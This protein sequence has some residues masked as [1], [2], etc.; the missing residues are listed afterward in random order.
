MTGSGSAPGPLVH[1][2]FEQTARRLPDKLALIV[3]GQ[4]L[5]YD[6]LAQRVGAA[7]AALARAGVLPGERVLVFLDSGIEFAVAMLAVWQRG[8]VLVPVSALTKSDK[9]AFVLAD[10]E[11]AGLMT[12]STLATVWQ[13]AIAGASQLRGVWVQG[14]VAD[15]TFA[16]CQPWPDACESDAPP[17]ATAPDDLAALIYTSGTTGR[18]KG[19]MLSHA[20]MCAAWR[21]VQA[22]L[23]LHEGDV[24]GLALSPA[25]S[26]GLYHLIMGLGIGATVLIERN[27]AFPVKV[28]QSLVAERVTVFPG[29]PTLFAALLQ[30]DLASHDLGALRLLTNAA[31]PLPPAH[32]DRLRRA[33]PHAR[34]FAMYGLTECKRASYLPP[35]ELDRRPGS[36]GRGMPFQEH[37]LA[38][39][40]GR[41]LPAGSTGELVVSGPHVMQGYW[42]RPEETALR[43][44]PGDRPGQLVLHTGDVFRSDADGF[45][46]FVS[47]SDDIIKSRGEKISPAEV[48]H[49]ICQLPDVMEAAVVGIP[50]DMLGQAVKA[51]VRLRPGAVMAEREVIRHCLARL[52]SFMAPKVVCFVE[53]LP[54]TESGKVRRASLKST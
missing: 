40:Q 50:D 10:T 12:Q 13:P 28:L 35:E 5:T 48:E 41:R 27:F 1:S 7:G 38:D 11:A 23:E 9:L 6:E 39:A 14:A 2:A 54:L 33:L 19:V 15:G 46:Y 51:Y 32:L 49:T 36:V 43:L 52:E 45:L 18:P 29:V 21:A 25:F 26:Y 8:A 3:A 4:R 53:S 42:R 37:W 16:G 34:F 30:Q 17:P 31:A 20:N 44:R 24:I 47:R 22:Y